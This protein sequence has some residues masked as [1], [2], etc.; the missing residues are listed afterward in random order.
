MTAVV[1]FAGITFFAAVLQAYCVWYL[2]HVAVQQLSRAIRGE[3]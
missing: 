2:A 1:A 3:P